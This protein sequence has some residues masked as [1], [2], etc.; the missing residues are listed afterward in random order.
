MPHVSRR[1]FLKLGAT[2][3]V[4]AATLPLLRQ[5][6]AVES[7]ENPLDTYPFRDW[8]QVYRDQYNYD[9]SFTFICSPNDTHACRLRAFTRN[10]VIQ[11]IEQNYDVGRYADQLGNTA[12]VKWH[13]RGCKKGMT[14]H[15][16]VYGP[17]RLKFPLVRAG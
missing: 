5:L 3:S 10:G 17:Y 2:V 15:R 8:E 1:D 16:R 4:G 14:F 6:G 11:R 7:I 13:P 12:S 9:D